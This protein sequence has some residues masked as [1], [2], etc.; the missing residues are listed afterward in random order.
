METKTKYFSPVGKLS[1]KQCLSARRTASQN[2]GKI[3]DENCAA[4]S[5]EFLI[6][7]KANFPEISKAPKFACNVIILLG[8]NF[9]S[10]IFF[11]NIRFFL[12]Y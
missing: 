11:Q 6:S 3:Y 2:E 5:E 8:F 12:L 10:S 9:I 7:L 1:Q 4:I